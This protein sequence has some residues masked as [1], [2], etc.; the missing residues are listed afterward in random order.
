[1]KVVLTHEVRGLGGPGDVVEVA[2]GYARNFLLPRKVA[3]RATRGVLAQVEQLRK[4]REVREVRN[5]ED[6][7]SIAKK[8]ESL[9]IRVKAKSGDSGR[10]FGQITGA[11]VAEAIQKAGGPKVDK[12][13]L[14]F[15]S[16]VKS[17]GTHTVHLRLHPEVE[18]TITVEVTKA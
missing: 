11:A 4:T 5:L 15:E 7:Q 18:A 12:K 9:Q 17:L 1:M 14:Q 8:L 16:P 3:Q 6:A 2:D 10:L 13:R